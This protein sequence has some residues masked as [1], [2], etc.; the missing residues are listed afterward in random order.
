MTIKPFLILLITFLV[1]SVAFGSAKPLAVIDLEPHPGG[2]YMMTINASVNGHQGRFIFDTAGGISYISPA[3]AKQI[4]CEPWGQLSGFVLTGQRLD[5]QRCEDV[6][7]DVAGWHMA[8]PTAGVYDIGKFMPPNTPRIDGSIGF[9]AFA[10]Q[11]VT[12]DLAG[13]KLVV[14][15]PSSLKARQKAGKEIKVRL[16]RELEGLA[17]AVVTAVQ[18]SKGLAWMELD[19]GNG[20]ANVIG[21]HLA[22]MF[23]LELEKKEPQDGRITLENGIDVAGPFR[24]NPT[25]IMDGNIGTRFMIGYE[26]T[27]DLAKGRAWLVSKK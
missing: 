11:A 15:S 13:K 12:L 26:L 6:S 4:G 18:T 17:L 16:V 3:F 24:V 27:F 19:S 23:N 20:G 5:M 7:F 21:K 22:S 8:V 9:D 1:T 14:E 10:G 25:L 2:T